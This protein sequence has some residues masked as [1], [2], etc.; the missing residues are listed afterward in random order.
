LAVAV[1]A[2]AADGVLLTAAAAAAVLIILWWLSWCVVLVLASLP[3]L[4]ILI[5]VFF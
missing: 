3:T 5:T 2:V 4:V 1:F